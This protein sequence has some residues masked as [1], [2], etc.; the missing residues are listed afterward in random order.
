MKPLVIVLSLA[1]FVLPPTAALA[2]QGKPKAGGAEKRKSC[3]MQAND[4]VRRANRG[5][6]NSEAMK[7]QARM[8]FE[9]CM[10]R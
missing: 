4:Q 5:G 10:A 1:A 3:Q 7:A 6:G 2:Q 8:Y 9:Q